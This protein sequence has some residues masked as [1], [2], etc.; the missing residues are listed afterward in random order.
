V[1]VAGG[2]VRH[3]DRGITGEATID[4]MQQFKV[5][6]AVMGISGIEN[7][8]TLL[9]FDYREVRVLQIIMNNARSILLGA[10]HSKFGRNALVR[11]GDLS[12]VSEL[13][14]DAQPPLPVRR[15]LNEH[16]V[17]LVVSGG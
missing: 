9:D 7:D 15:L 5:D 11:V 8:G 17:R 1:I 12:Q 14:T 3:R 2:V 4:F 16:G 6:Y 10:D 13:F